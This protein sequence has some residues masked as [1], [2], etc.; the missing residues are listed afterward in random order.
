MTVLL[1]ESNLK[2]F[3]WCA[4]IDPNIA[5]FTRFKNNYCKVYFVIR[6]SLE[7]LNFLKI[8]SLDGLLRRTKTV[9]FSYDK[10]C[11]VQI[12]NG[13]ACNIQER[14]FFLRISRESHWVSLTI[15]ALT[16]K[17]EAFM[18]LMFCI[19]K[20]EKTVFLLSIRRR[21]QSQSTEL[22]CCSFAL[23][24][25]CVILRDSGAV[26]WFQVRAG[27]RLTAWST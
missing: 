14:S 8:S 6:S 23:S 22:C 24:A 5:L 2:S 18:Q 10:I 16:Q 15:N 4:S 3:K 11:C 26:S 25:C 17:N 19:D 20:L 12:T 7:K 13:G 21:A 1:V 9:R 27:G